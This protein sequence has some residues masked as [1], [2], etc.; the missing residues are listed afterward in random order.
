MARIST[1][2]LDNVLNDDDI[3]VGSDGATQEYSTKNFKLSDIASYSKS[4]LSLAPTLVLSSFSDVDQ[5]PSGLD[6]RLQVVFGSATGTSSDPV[7]LLADGSI[8]FNQAGLYLFNGY[9]NF[10]RQGASGGITVTAFRALL[11][12]VQIMPVKAVELEKPGIMLPYELT[13][14][15]NAQVGDVMTW[16]IMRDSSG[17]D[18]GGLYTHALS[19]GWGVVPSTD[20]NIWK[21]GL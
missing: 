16:E 3:V 5:E 7:Q 19:G 14:P 18:E 21:I 12:G 2:G 8:V 1:Y 13:V 6:A 20:I 9:G 11:N 15:I 10:E 17:Q 4:K